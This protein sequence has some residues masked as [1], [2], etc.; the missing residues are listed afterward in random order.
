[1]S[2]KFSR[3]ALILRLPS[4]GVSVIQCA[5]VSIHCSAII[6][7]PQIC[8][9][10]PNKPHCNEIWYGNSPLFAFSPPA[11]LSEGAAGIFVI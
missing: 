9:Q 4:D 7:P 6:E 11:I 1:M 3:P 8:D 5:A 2:S 10:I